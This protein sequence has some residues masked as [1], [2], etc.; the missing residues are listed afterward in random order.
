M[1]RQLKI[2]YVYLTKQRINGFFISYYIFTTYLLFNSIF[3][4]K[5][6]ISR[7]NTNLNLSISFLLKE[8]TEWTEYFKF[9]LF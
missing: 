7:L 2:Y 5:I 9:F 3:E 4:K 8:K 1:P 6:E